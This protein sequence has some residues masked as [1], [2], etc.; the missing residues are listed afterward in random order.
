MT[1]KAGSTL[2]RICDMEGKETR[3]IKMKDVVLV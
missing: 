3:D 2:G 1:T